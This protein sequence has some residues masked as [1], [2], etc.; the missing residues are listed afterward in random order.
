[1]LPFTNL[2]NHPEQQYFA[3][4]ITEDLTADL[5]RIGDMFVIS[6]STAF[7]YRDKPI[8]TKQIGRELGVRYGSKGASGDRATR[9]AS[10][11]S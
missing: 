1:V 6:R 7:T 11:P 4:G 8:S 3:D 9:C 2:S 5:S 10:L